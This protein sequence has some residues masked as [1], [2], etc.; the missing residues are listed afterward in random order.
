MVC[1][2]CRG[3]ARALQLYQA[4]IA[5]GSWGR[6]A[7]EPA[8]ARVRIAGVT[9]SR[10]TSPTASTVAVS[11]G[12]LHVFTWGERAR[13]RCSPSTGSPPRRTPGRAWPRRCPTTGGWSPPTCA[14]AATP[15]T[16]PGR[17]AWSGTPP[18]SARWPTT[19]APKVTWCWSATRW[20][21]TSR[22][23]LPARDPTSS[24]ASSSSTAGCP[25]RCRRTPTPTRS[26]RPRS[27]R[28]WTPARDA[29][30][31]PT[32]T[33]T[34]SGSTPRWGRTGATSSRSTC[35]TTCSRPT[36]ASSR[37]AARS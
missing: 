15:A 20:A 29:T 34:S 32:P 10:T 33:S 36:T 26:W 13:A 1:S 4:S 17:A 6:R 5:T 30:P 37:G 27:A 23:S 16:C 35:A 31:T 24:A 14:V 2:S 18:T 25:C 9:L 8:S 22:C 19:S 3:K 28:R 21:P 12:D 11:G 7:C